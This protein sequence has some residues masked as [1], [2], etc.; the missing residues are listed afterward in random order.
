M[1]RRTSHG[2]VLGSV[3]LL[4]ACGGSGAASGEIEIDAALDTGTEDTGTPDTGTPDTSVDTGSP[5][6]GSPD[7]GT[8]DTTPLDTGTPDTGTPDTTPVDTGTPFDASGVDCVT[9]T[10][11][12]GIPDEIEGRYEKTGPVDT[13][14]D[15]TP[16]YLD[17]DSD[18]DGISD[19]DEWFDKGSCSPGGT[20][21]ADGDGVP[22]Y[23]DLDS[24]GNGLPD[25]DEACPPTTV[26]T[27]LGKAAC[28]AG[29]PYDFDGDGV[30]DYLDPDNDHDSTSA[31]KSVGLDDKFE[32]GAGGVLTDTDGDGVPDLYDT[33]SDGDGILDLEDG[34]GDPDKDGKPNFRDTDSDG[35]GVPD[36]CEGLV[37]TDGDGKADYVDTDSD[38]DYLADALEDKNGNCKVD[39]GETNR[40]KKDTDGDGHD[41]FVETALTPVGSSSWAT[42]ATKTPW[43][44]GKFY[45]LVPY[46]FDGSAKPSPTSTPLAMSTKINDGD[47]AFVVDTTTSMNNVEA[48]LSTSIGK[49]ITDLTDSSKSTYIPN[50]R[51]GVV[52]YDDA[53]AKPWG[54]SVGDSFVWFPGGLDRVTAT[55]STAISAAAALASKGTTPGGSYPEGTVPALWWV[56][57]GESFSFVSTTVGTTKTF[58][59]VTGLAST[60]FGGLH[61]RKSAVPI[62][63]NA[64]DANMHGGKTSNCIDPGGATLSPCLPISYGTG[65]AK[66]SSLTTSVDID[67]LIAKM[68]VIG[69]K[70]VGISVHGGVGGVTGK[71]SNV[72]RTLSTT[73]YSSSLDME[74]IAKGTNSMVDPTAISATATTS[75]CK[76]SNA[77]GAANP[78]TAG[79][80]P[81]V[82]DILYDGAGLGS[83]VT[84]GIVALLKSIRYDVH[85]QATPVLSGGVDPVD[86]FMTNVLPMPGGGTDPV[87]GGTC[88]TFASTST[89]DRF[90]GPKAAP[91]TDAA[92]ETILDVNPGPLH[93]FAVAPKVNTTV[94]ATL[95]VQIFKATLR[96][97]AEKPDGTTFTLGTDREVLFLVPPLV[98]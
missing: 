39:A 18:N 79:K 33:D 67:L 85:V 63:V 78:A 83:V 61:F 11:K 80:C 9:D 82:F 91:G 12:D 73:A 89:A 5:D 59:A 55:P 45:F 90:I 54:D 95:A 40:L 36:S 21:D 84:N 25:K 76:T 72:S 16:D 94:P 66:P 96:V 52:G 19:K 22:N 38:G 34:L 29:V 14:K 41:D 57:T 64:S 50:L 1:I 56:L 47:V 26:L 44:Q 13:D 6:T 53:L 23:R 35:D 71:A 46:S 86:A 42:D 37:D 65:G 17:T 75:D 28:V 77:G 3:L 49:I 20:N 30:P 15:G 60:E 70:Y 27:K 62:L 2:F 74:T 43:N 98:N 4:G 93:C 10:D 31:D 97:E 32:V 8:P 24:D 69:A 88:V 87:T 92:K 58:P 51:V 81:L 48:A 68:N 7:T